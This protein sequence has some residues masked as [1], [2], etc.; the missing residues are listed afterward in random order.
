MLAPDKGDGTG[1]AAGNGGTTDETPKAGPTQKAKLEAAEKRVSELEG[2]LAANGDLQAKLDAANG[3][4]E[5]A[6]KAKADAES[7]LET[8]KATISGLEGEKAQLSEQVTKLQ[9]QVGQTSDRAGE[10]LSAAGLNPGTPKQEPAAAANSDA[11]LVATWENY[12]KAGPI[13]AA[14]MRATLG[15]KLDAAAVAYD[16]AQLSA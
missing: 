7:A 15:A 5:A 2:Q 16:R 14:E 8:A 3:K 12:L 9:G 1:A 4:I 13:D 10:Q 6:E 11:D